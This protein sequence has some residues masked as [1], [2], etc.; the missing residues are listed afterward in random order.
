VRSNVKANLTWAHIRD[1]RRAAVMHAWADEHGY[2]YTATC[3]LPAGLQNH[4][5]GLHQ[6][7]G[8]VHGHRASIFD[9]NTAAEEAGLLI[10]GPGRRSRLASVAVLT[11]DGPWP[12]QRRTSDAAGEPPRWFIKGDQAIAWWPNPVAP[13]TMWTAVNVLARN[14]GL[15]R[16]LLPQPRRA[17][18]ED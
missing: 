2:E 18:T 17:P 11:N 15:T 7:M 13:I 16:E 14:L 4:G 1:T 10:W 8:A 12:S 5:H 3:T 6:V 9:V